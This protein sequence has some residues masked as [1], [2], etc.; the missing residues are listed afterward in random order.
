MHAAEALELARLA[1]PAFEGAGLPRLTPE[2]LSPPAS[3]APLLAA[4]SLSAAKIL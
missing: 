2:V 4:G 3:A 1:A